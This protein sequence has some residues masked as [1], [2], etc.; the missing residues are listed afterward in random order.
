[1]FEYSH[2]LR[3]LTVSRHERAA[4]VLRQR[5]TSQLQYSLQS[6]HARTQRTACSMHT[7]CC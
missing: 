6:Y 7:A 4:V 3:G 5:Q 1:M 2:H